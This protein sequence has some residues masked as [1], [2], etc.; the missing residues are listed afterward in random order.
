VSAMNARTMT[1]ATTVSAAKALAAVRIATGIIFFLFAEYKIVGNEFTP[2]GFIH[3]VGGWVEQSQPVGFFL[4]VLANFALVH[5]VICARIVAWGEMAIAVSLILGVLVRPASVWGGV[6]MISLALS[7]WFAP[8]HGAPVWQYFGANLDH[9][10]LLLLFV[11]FYAT[12]AGTVW[13]LDGRVR[14]AK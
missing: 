1:E 11:I 8:G 6:F 5:P 14:R 3:W 9:I 10:S 7:T 2:G 4:P 13:G 12:R